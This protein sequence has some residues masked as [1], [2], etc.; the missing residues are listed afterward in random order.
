MEFVA[1]MIFVLFIGFIAYKVKE[2]KD[3]P[4]N[5]SGSG[6]GGRNPGDPPIRER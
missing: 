6:G 2:S 3:K 1:G 5:T 4:K